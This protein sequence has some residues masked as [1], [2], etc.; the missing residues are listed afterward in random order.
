MH[1][2][3]LKTTCVC[4]IPITISK[5]LRKA[6]KQKTDT[7][8]KKNESKF[9]KFWDYKVFMLI[10][11]HPALKT[12]SEIENYDKQ[13]FVFIFFMKKFHDCEIYSKL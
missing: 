9:V 4:T 3:G 7:Y 8:G 10:G 13:K 12:A 5:C 11:Q 2:F 6:L 1:E